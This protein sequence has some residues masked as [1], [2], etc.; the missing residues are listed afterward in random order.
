MAA[1]TRMTGKDLQVTFAGGTITG[2]QT[3]FSVSQSEDLVDVTAGSDAVHYHIPTRS[4]WTA[5]FETFFNGSTLT[6]WDTMAPGAV[7]T[8][9]WHPNGTASGNDIFT[10]TRVIVSGRDQSHP[11]DGGSTYT[12]NFQGSA[13]ITQTVVS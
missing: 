3:A 7:G 10:C 6:V 2:D 4:D 11:F 9:T 1:T 5:T 8:M 13:A 12:V